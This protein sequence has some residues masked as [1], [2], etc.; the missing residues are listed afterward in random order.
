MVDDALA[1]YVPITERLLAAG[2]LDLA[3]VSDA[4]L[5]VVLARAIRLPELAEANAGLERFVPRDA[6][7]TPIAGLSLITLNEVGDPLGLQA[8]QLGPDGCRM[9]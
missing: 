3:T 2:G 7:G 8:A 5:E 4:E 9:I 1:G 6:L